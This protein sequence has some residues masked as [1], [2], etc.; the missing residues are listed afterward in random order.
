MSGK[1][2]G[3]NGIG[4]DMEVGLLAALASSSRRSRRAA[5]ILR[6][7][8]LIARPKENK[9]NT[10][11]LPPSAPANVAISCFLTSLRRKAILVRMLAEIFNRRKSFLA[12]KKI[13]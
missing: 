9:L 3:T 4:P 5:S 12:Q 10:P 2:L 1:Y 13:T 8:I 7:M 11:T 6:R